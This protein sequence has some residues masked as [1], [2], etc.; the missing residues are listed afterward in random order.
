MTFTP[1]F[2]VRRSGMIGI[3]AA[4]LLLAGCSFNR[5]APVKGTYLL[6]PT[7]PT[8]ATR[9]QPGSLRVAPMNVAAPYRGR[10][11][12]YR[13]SDLKFVSD[14]YEEFLVAPGAM[15]TEAT[16]RA[17]YA[18]KSF[19]AV[20]PI[21]QLA[22][23]TFTLDGFVGAIYGDMRDRGKPVAVL[24]ITYF[25]TRSGEGAPL[26][27]RSYARRLPVAG[28]TPAAFVTALNTALTEILAE[29]VRDL[30]A[31]DLPRG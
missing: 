31:L 4:V 7:L 14:Y 30:A 9:T 12:V 10:S 24:E 1:S 16:G 15:I 23:A 3:V 21:A 20:G 5:E 25:L 27:S 29:L 18:A 13:E 17:L 28:A 19:A 8:V 6:E 2:A 22:D 11:F 26:W